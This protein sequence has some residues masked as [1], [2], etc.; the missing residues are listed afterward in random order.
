MQSRL[1][2]ATVQKA[3]SFI[4]TANPKHTPH[5][6]PFKLGTQKRYAINLQNNVRHKKN[7]ALCR[8]NHI[9]HNSNYIRPFS[10]FSIRLNTNN[11]QRISIFLTY[12]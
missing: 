12:L 1:L 9:R 6:P 7:H 4:C 11:L 5:F 3:A 10:L 8:K 2:T